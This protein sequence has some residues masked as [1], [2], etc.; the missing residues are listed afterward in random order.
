[1]IHQLLGRPVHLWQQRQK[2]QEHARLQQN[3][4]QP[5]GILRALRVGHDFAH[6]NVKA[7]VRANTARLRRKLTKQ[8]VLSPPGALVG[9]GGLYGEIGEGV[10]PRRGM[11]REPGAQAEFVD[12]APRALANAQPFDVQL[13]HVPGIAVFSK[14]AGDA[15]DFAT[16]LKE[17]HRN[18]ASGK[19]GPCNEA[20]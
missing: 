8:I 13:T 17:I 3:G 2:A 10:E 7:I 6:A 5:F 11:Q 12:N 14:S 15:A 4:A 19:I 20:R 1:V 18:A 16:L 9:G